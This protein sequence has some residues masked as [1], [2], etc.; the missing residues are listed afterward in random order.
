MSKPFNKN[1]KPFNKNLL[2][3]TSQE[4]ANVI[5]K[6]KPAIDK[7]DKKLAELYLKKILTRTWIVSYQE[8]MDIIE[9]IPGLLKFQDE[10]T[11][12]YYSVD[13]QVEK[14]EGG[15]KPSE[16]YLNLKYQRGPFIGKAIQFIVC[17]GGLNDTMLLNACINLSVATGKKMV[18]DGGMRTLMCMILGY[19]VPAKVTTV[20]RDSFEEEVKYEAKQFK[21]INISLRVMEWEKIFKSTVCAEDDLVYKEFAILLEK[22]GLNVEDMNPNNV[23][24]NK[25]KATFENIYLKTSGKDSYSEDAFI[26]AVDK[27]KNVFNLYSGDDILISAFESIAMIYEKIANNNYPVSFQDKFTIENLSIGLENF[28]RT[29][30]N[31]NKNSQNKLI[32]GALVNNKLNTRECLVLDRLFNLD[33]NDRSDLIDFFDD[34]EDENKKK[35][36]KIDFTFAKNYIKGL[37]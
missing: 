32:A 36:V 8:I 11:G 9:D 33:E 29:K 7:A 10:Y 35:K 13:T 30:K 14:V 2:E 26:Y 21:M 5:A 31:L 28:K 1:L 19:D 34:D 27:T 24:M 15:V 20:I 4:Q 12:Q 22:V 23:N 37:L 16:C 6:Y 17:A 25:A 3:L 18:W